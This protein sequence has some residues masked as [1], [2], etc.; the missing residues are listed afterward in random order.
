MLN[1]SAKNVLAKGGFS[2]LFLG[3]QASSGTIFKVMDD[4]LNAAR[5][6]LGGFHEGLFEL[7]SVFI[8]AS[9]LFF[10]F[11]KRGSQNLKII[12][13]PIGSIDLICRTS[14]ETILLK[15]PLDEIYNKAN[16]LF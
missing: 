8:K 3:S 9:K 6:F 15:N 16:K 4:F 2:E 1:K 13:A 7:A 14:S 10:T 5:N 12:S 11:L